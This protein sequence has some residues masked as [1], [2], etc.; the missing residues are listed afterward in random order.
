VARDFTTRLTESYYA[1]FRAIVVD[2]SL[3][4]SPPENLVSLNEQ[5]VLMLLAAVAL[6]TIVF[7]GTWGATPGQRLLRLRIIPAPPLD[8]AAPRDRTIPAEAAAVR[9]GW[10]AAIWRGAAWAIL[11][12]GSPLLVFQVFSVFMVLWHPRRQTLPD[13]FARTVVIRLPR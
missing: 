4:A 5:L 3:G 9:L 10:F 6:Y 11:M 2:P 7:L 1:W 12:A 13:L 8:P